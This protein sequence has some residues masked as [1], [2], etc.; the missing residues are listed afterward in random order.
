MHV[1]NFEF[2]VV[3]S[4]KITPFKVVAPDE[5]AFI[6]RVK[7]STREF[8]PIVIRVISVLTPCN[9]NVVVWTF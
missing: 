3:P 5:L 2:V 8:T 9:C 4:G 7:S 6:I 1:R